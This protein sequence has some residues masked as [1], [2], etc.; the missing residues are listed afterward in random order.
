ML[1]H[2]C[3]LTLFQ[4]EFLNAISSMPSE[5]RLRTKTKDEDERL[6]TKT[7]DENENFHLKKNRQT[8]L[9]STLHLFSVSN[10]LSF[11][12]FDY[13]FFL[14]FRSFSFILFASSK[15]TKQEKNNGVR[16]C[17]KFASPELKQPNSQ[18]RRD[19][20]FI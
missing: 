5:G 1:K 20:F 7:K 2:N 11:I 19:F 17:L 4:C 3:F 9:P 12:L 8:C 6:R 15:R 10:T 18:A 16:K 14:F 13:T